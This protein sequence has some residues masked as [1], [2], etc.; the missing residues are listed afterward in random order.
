MNND[1]L[2]WDHLQPQAG[3]ALACAPNG[4]DEDYAVI[5]GYVIYFLG[6]MMLINGIWFFK[7]VHQHF[8]LLLKQSDLGTKRGSSSMTQKFDFKGSSLRENRRIGGLKGVRKLQKAWKH[9][10][11]DAYIAMVLGVSNMS[12]GI[13]YLLSGGGTSHSVDELRGVFGD[14]FCKSDPFVFALNE[15]CNLRQS[16]CYHDTSTDQVQN[17]ILDNRVEF[18]LTKTDNVYC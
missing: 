10:P 17:E 11:N 12:A 2:Y 16:C 8:V 13:A 1:T 7:T 5:C 9:L 14:G 18:L 3:Q 4:G 6:S 15:C